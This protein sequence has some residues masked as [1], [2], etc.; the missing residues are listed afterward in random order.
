MKKPFGTVE[1]PDQR[2]DAG[3]GHIG[4]DVPAPRRAAARV[5]IERKPGFF[6]SLGPE[7]RDAIMQY[8]GPEVMGP[9]RR[10]GAR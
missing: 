6:A 3:A 2:T 9:P 1:D 4:D 10:E 5:R 8:E 7:A